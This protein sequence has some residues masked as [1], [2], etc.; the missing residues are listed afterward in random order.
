MSKDRLKTVV[1]GCMWCGLEEKEAEA[2]RVPC[3]GRVDAGALLK[4]FRDGVSGVLV[5]GCAACDCHYKTG[6]RLAA[7]TVAGVRELLR[8]C[9]IKPERL[10]FREARRR[11]DDAARAM[12]D[13]ENA[14]R[15]L[16]PLRT[17]REARK[18]G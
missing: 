4:A 13:F 14:I 9:G 6:S 3:S 11:T 5:L 8:A 16:G 10:A 18:D 15:E 7:E 12:V 2:V 17:A 1:I